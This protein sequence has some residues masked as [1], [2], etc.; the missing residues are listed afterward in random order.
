MLILSSGKKKKKKLLLKPAGLHLLSKSVLIP[1]TPYGSVPALQDLAGNGTSWTVI[2]GCRPVQRWGS[3]P[4]LE[5]RRAA[6]ISQQSPLEEE[7]LVV[8]IGCGPKLSPG[9]EHRQG[10]EQGWE[11]IKPA[12][13]TLWK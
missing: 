4:D 2:E 5:P 11:P 3:T 12:Q 13:G 10:Q 9:W 7:A 1:K 6:R 8:S